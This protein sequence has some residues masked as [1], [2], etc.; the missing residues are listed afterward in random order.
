METVRKRLEPDPRQTHTGLDVL[1]AEDNA[2]AARVIA[3]FLSRLG[4]RVTLTKDG[5]ATLEQARRQRFDIAFIDLRMPRIDGLDFTRSYRA[6]ETEDD[7]LPII[8]LTANTVEDVEREALEAGMD[9][10]LTKPVDL[11]E[12]REII[13]RYGRRSKS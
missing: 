13:R 2:I 6:D 8:A 7:R 10:L 1:V 5:E 4:H 3:A 11:E 9:D 12:L